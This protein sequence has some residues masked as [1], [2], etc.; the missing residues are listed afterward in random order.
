MGRI[1][2]EPD[3][4]TAV[5]QIKNNAGVECHAPLDIPLFVAV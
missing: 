5:Y 4:F 2:A 1:H 3:G